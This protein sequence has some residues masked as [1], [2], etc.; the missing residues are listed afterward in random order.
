MK[1]ISYVIMILLIVFSLSACKD[2]EEEEMVVES[3]VESEWIYDY[4]GRKTIKVNEKL[5]I[6]FCKDNR[7]GTGLWLSNSLARMYTDSNGKEYISLASG[8]CEIFYDKTM[9]HGFDLVENGLLTLEELE[10]LEFPF[11]EVID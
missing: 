6:T 3:V 7:D 11:S 2:K 1:R 5:F 9:Y 8:A 10:L 4:I